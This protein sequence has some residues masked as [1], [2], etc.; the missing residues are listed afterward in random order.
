MPRTA[1]NKGIYSSPPTDGGGNARLSV[2]GTTACL[3]IATCL[4]G[5]DESTCVADGDTIVDTP[6]AGSATGADSVTGLG[7]AAASFDKGMVS[8]APLGGMA[9]VVVLA[10][11]DCSALFTTVRILSTEAATACFKACSTR[12][13]KIPIAAPNP[14]TIIALQIHKERCAV[15]SRIY[16]KSAVRRRTAAS[17]SA[18]RSAIGPSTP[19]RS[20]AA[21]IS[22]STKSTNLAYARKYPLT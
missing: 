8:V 6:T 11:V 13:H 3:F 14:K 21:K 22:S 16:A 20:K 1:W 15:R 19:I 4:L 12:H 2:V 10:G 5:C 18:R 9:T 17:L 7:P